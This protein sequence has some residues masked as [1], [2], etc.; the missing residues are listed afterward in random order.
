MD[1]ETTG[2]SPDHGA[3]LIEVC[4]LLFS[5]EHKEML[6]IYSTLIACQVNS[7]ELINNIK[8]VV[9]QQLAHDPLISS[10]H[11]L[12]NMMQEAD[13]LV[14]HNAPFD[15]KFLT[16]TFPFLDLKRW[17]CTCKQFQWPLS[18]PRKRLQDICEA[19]NIPYLNAHRAYSD[20]LLLSWCLAEVKD[21]KERLNTC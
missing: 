12:F 8:P 3:Q 11:V 20:C 19:Y 7:A 5:I 13:A 15:H 1:C 4:G 10:S 21:L 6:Q 2:L 14:A 16:K 9:T 17:I 18:L